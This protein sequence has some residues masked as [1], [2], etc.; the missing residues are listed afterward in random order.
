MLKYIGDFDKLK[1]FGFK[2]LDYDYVSNKPYEIPYC[3]KIVKKF[4]RNRCLMLCIEDRIIYLYES[5][6]IYYIIKKRIRKKYIDDLI[7]A[8]LVEKG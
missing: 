7:K 3:S 8:G 1:E 4:S 2:I 5:R 6:K